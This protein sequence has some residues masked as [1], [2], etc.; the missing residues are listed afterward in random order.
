VVTRE[1]I[2]FA[3]NKGEGY[4]LFPAKLLNFPQ[5]QNKIQIY[6]KFYS[7]IAEEG[8]AQRRPS[9]IYFAK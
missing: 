9:A 2:A 3:L 4:F 8:Q 7:V 6:L 5:Q 1:H